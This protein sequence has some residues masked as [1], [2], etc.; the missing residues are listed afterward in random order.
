MARGLTDS[1]A[2]VKREREVQ[3][4]LR[5]IRDLQARM[6]EGLLQFDEDERAAAELLCRLV[7]GI[8][9]SYRCTLLRPLP[10][11]GCGCFASHRL[12]ED[13]RADLERC[14]SQPGFCD[15]S[16]ASEPDGRVFVVDLAPHAPRP[17]ETH[18]SARDTAALW[19]CA[20]VI[21][22]EGHQLGILS[23]GS[24]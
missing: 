3:S 9:P 2:T 6:L 5:A 1:F 21:G 7:E 15:A 24:G 17:E 18:G 16:G 13:Q 23:I 19:W 12:G 10:T 11:G 20:P 22:H 14:F 8:V 4:R